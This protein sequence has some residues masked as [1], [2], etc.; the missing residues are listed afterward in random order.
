MTVL[1]NFGPSH[2]GLTQS[3]GS[4][5]SLSTK[6][7]PSTHLLQHLSTTVFKQPNTILKVLIAAIMRTVLALVLLAA[8]AVATANA[9]SE[10]LTRLPA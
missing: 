8:A 2:L 7:C 1:E 9:Q 5:Y 10:L 4:E 6:I 3:L